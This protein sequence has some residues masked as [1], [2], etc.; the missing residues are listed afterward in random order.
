MTTN[1]IRI[2]IIFFS[3]KSAQQQPAQKS[4]ARAA[5]KRQGTLM[6]P[7]LRIQSWSGAATAA[8]TLLGGVQEY[9]HLCGC[10]GMGLFCRVQ[11]DRASSSVSAISK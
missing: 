11:I 8:S 10:T 5:P 2:I 4:Q 6:N 9:F 3:F 7:R 1:S